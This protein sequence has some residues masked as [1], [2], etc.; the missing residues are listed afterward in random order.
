MGSYARLYLDD[1]LLDTSKEY[2]NPSIMV[3][4]SSQD[5]R[6]IADVP[7]YVEGITPLDDGDDVQFP[8]VKY[9]ASLR[10]IADRLDV[11]GITLARSKAEFDGGCQRRLEELHTHTR[12][13]KQLVDIGNRETRL[14][15]G[16]TFDIWL[17]KFADIVRE[18][19]SPP[20]HQWYELPESEEYDSQIMAYMRSEWSNGPFGFQSHDFRFFLRAAI[21]IVGTDHELCYD[22]SELMGDGYYEDH[23]DLFYFARQDMGDEASIRHKTVVL[24]EGSTD[25]T[26][27]ERSLQ[28]LYPHLVEHYS[29][30]DFESVRAPGGAS[31]LVAT[32]KAFVGAG[33]A[34]RIVALFDNDTAAQSALR[35]LD[36][37]S[38]PDTVRVLRFPEIRL[39]GNY[40]TLGPQ[41]L[42]NM[43]VNGLA[44]SIELYFGSDVLS[45]EHGQYVPIQW[46][47]YDEALKQYQGEIMNKRE[48][49]QRFNAKLSAARV[50]AQLLKDC[51]WTGIEAILKV[52][53]TAFC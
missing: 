15:Y 50:D 26:V 36:G 49:H 12:Q 20:S 39:A 2:I 7:P 24:T 51:D 37:I 25:K 53:R 6:V 14:L 38:L 30:L 45:D 44:A 31:V 29:F 19:D 23:D 35:A 21:E 34:N 18:P 22:V 4:F 46:R 52:L 8:R 43:D 32:V 28:I 40:P 5:R 33:I 47:G 41:G 3:M 10:A 9:V 48:L 17:D 1:L 11:M 42:T 27:L 13:Y 16:L